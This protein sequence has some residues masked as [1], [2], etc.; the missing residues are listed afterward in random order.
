MEMPL[1]PQGTLHGAD[2]W[3]RHTSFLIVDVVNR[4]L[5]R[6]RFVVHAAS[7]LILTSYLGISNEIS[8]YRK[9]HKCYAQL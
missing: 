9:I 6:T 3:N 5:L 4:Y 8:K 2:F 1:V 7:S